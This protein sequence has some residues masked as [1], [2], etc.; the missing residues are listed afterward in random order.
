MQKTTYNGITTKQARAIACLLSTRTARDAA[1]AAKVGEKTLYTWL[2]D[3]AF[4]VALRSAEADML[5]TVTRRL[6]SGQSLALDA[7]ETLITKAKHEST[8]R[9]AAIDWLNLSLKFIDTVNI[10]E[11][12]TALEAAINDNKK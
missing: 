11:R 2:A 12:L 5:A 6:S 8:R 10:D 1:R 9:Q 3:P 7:L 4:R